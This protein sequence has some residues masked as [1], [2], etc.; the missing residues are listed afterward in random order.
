MT[1]GPFL[2]AAP[3]ALLGL[4]AL[5]VIWWVLRATPPMPKEAE[6]PS[7][8][9]L[10]DLDPSEETPAQTPWWI[11]ALRLAAA[12]LAALGLAQPVYAPGAKTAEDTGA[13]LI[14]MD[15]GWT[16][17]ARWRE[18]TAAA[19]GALDTAA[20][21]TAVHLLLTAPRDRPIDPAERLTR[22]DMA[23][24]IASL[25]PAAWAPDRMDALSRLEASGLRP[26][27]ILWASDG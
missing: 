27:R 3:W 13:L 1:L 21:D 7:L 19:D 22:R 20:R 4:L 12:G 16:S 18:L 2:F 24:R 14:V 11:L 6:L 26:A 17:A 23:Q 8:R 25:E 10:D 9:L 5:P 15:D